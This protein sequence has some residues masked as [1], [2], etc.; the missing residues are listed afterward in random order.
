[1]NRKRRKLWIGLVIVLLAG[2]AVTVVN[3]Q[4]E[5]PTSVQTARV[6]RVATLESIVTAT[7][8]V[9]AKEAVDIQAEVAGVI[10]ELPVSEGEWIEKDQV[11]V[12]IDPFQTQADLEAMRAYLAAGE[13]DA[14][15]QQVRI[16]EAE[17]SLARDLAFKKGAEADLVQT[18][19][20]LQLAQKTHDR[21]SDLFRNNVV[22]EEEL[23]NA[24]MELR[25]AQAAKEA[26]LARIDQY[27]A[28]AKATRLSIEQ[29]Q[30]AHEAVIQRALAARANMDRAE[31]SH[32]KT[33]IR[34][35]L[36]GL[37]THLNVEAGERAVPGILSN[38]QAT[39]M[40][41]ADMSTLEV[42]L[43]VD[44]TD[45]VRVSLG[46]PVEVIVDALP[47]QPIQGLVTEIGNAPIATA[48]AQ[49]GK[50][51]LV[52]AALEAPP[53]V[54]RPGMSCEGDITTDVKV[55][56]LV[57]PIQA[58]T[59][60]EVP[61]T[62]EGTYERGALA[63]LQDERK[64]RTSSAI[65]RATEN[66]KELDGVFIRGPEERALFCPVTTGTTGEMDIELLS[67]LTEGDEVVIGPFKA[68]RSLK[69]RELLRVDNSDFKRFLKRGEERDV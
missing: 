8:T 38:P 16:A 7:G 31:D 39:L 28:Q 20:R 5:K 43:K 53:E 48:G 29:A 65:A 12:R 30:A 37:L 64:Q 11:L 27:E 9:E 35:P 13:A 42:W 24:A 61:V 50:D 62:P 58:L 21:R 68:L 26:I 32:N 52:K 3:A 2:V 51:F 69:E 67:G 49:E 36:R 57:V 34:S 60:R 33:T 19:V 17:A 56:V 14:K 59:R 40:T 66:T 6:E 10:V 55:N 1:M 25:A 63:R 46:D 15:A 54:L 47:E 41:I 23:D 4:R 18:E 22:S 45:I 44:E